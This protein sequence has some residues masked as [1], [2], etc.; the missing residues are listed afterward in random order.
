MSADISSKGIQNA[1]G[2]HY[3]ATHREKLLLQSRDATQRGW[4]QSTKLKLSRTHAK[5]QAL[6]LSSR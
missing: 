1:A 6:D 4:S 3:L 2:N 5:C